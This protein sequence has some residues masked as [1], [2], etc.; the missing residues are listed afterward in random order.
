MTAKDYQERAQ[1]TRVQDAPEAD[2]HEPGKI[3]DRLTY[4]SATLQATLDGLRSA[5]STHIDSFIR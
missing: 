3:L 1:H 5:R 2:A 4:T